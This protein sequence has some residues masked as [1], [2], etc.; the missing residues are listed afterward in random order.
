[1]SADG[2]SVETRLSAIEEEL[3]QIKLL[4]AAKVHDTGLPWWKQIMGSHENDPVFAEIVE[5]GQ[6]I[7]KKGQAPSL[8]AKKK[9]KINSG[10]SGKA[11]AQE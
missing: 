4:L 8:H 7:R 1:M 10:G 2:V 6:Q 5:L 11:S 3:R 9:R